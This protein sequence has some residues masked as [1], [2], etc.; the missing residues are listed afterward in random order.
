VDIVIEPINADLESV[1]VIP[2]EDMGPRWFV[3]LRA[4]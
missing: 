4:P 1:Y 3:R 2:P